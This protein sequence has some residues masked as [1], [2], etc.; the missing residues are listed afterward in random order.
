VPIKIEKNGE[1]IDLVP[2]KG[3]GRPKGSKDKTKR[4]PPRHNTVQALRKKILGLEKK[5]DEVTRENDRL[6]RGYE[7]NPLVLVRDP[8]RPSTPE[9]IEQIAT[10]PTGDVHPGGPKKAEDEKLFIHDRRS[11]VARLM[12]RGVPQYQIA[13]HLNVG[14]ATV[15]ADIRAVRDQWRRNVTDYSISEAVGESLDFY[16]EIR[17]LAIREASNATNKASDAIS[18]MSTA[19]KA[20]DSKNAFLARLGLWDLLHDEKSAAF[21]GRSGRALENDSDDFSKVVS[22]MAGGDNAGKTIE[23]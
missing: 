21:K 19:L 18:A 5:V 2:H 7:E 4:K 17:D 22:F 10:T 16:R 20:E 6:A 15:S 13:E 8:A 14:T 12:L 9:E 11:R 3:R 1:V 23:H